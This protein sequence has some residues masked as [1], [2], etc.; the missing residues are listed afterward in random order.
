MICLLKFEIIC[1][2]SLRI[3]RSKHEMSDKIWS[4]QSVVNNFLLA[5]Y[6][7][8]IKQPSDE[9][10]EDQEQGNISTV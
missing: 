3:L 2:E 6:L 9:N 8:T 4:Q 10:K 1:Q 7:N 5:N